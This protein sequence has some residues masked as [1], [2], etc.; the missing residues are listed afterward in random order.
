MAAVPVAVPAAPFL[1]PDNG[2]YYEAVQTP[3]G[4]TWDAAHAAAQ[5]LTH[6]GVTGHLATITSAAENQFIVRNFPQAITGGFW[7]G[8]VQPHGLLDPAAGWQWVTGEPFGYTNWNTIEFVEPNDFWGPGTGDQDENRL[9][10]WF[11]AEGRWN[12]LRP[13]DASPQ[14]YVVEYATSPGTVS[15]TNAVLFV[16]AINGVPTEGRPDQ[17]TINV[18]DC[19]TLT[20][21][22]KFR[23]GEFVDITH[24]P[25][26]RFFTEL[27]GQRVVLPANNFCATEAERNKIFTIY[28]QNFSPVAGQAITDTVIV[29]VRR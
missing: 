17:V 20:Y 12:D 19:V 7:L 24:S 1:N 28:G 27:G 11:S 14:G 23:T 10:Y 9:H 15:S 22:V 5:S 4:V 26:T 3:G 13:F 8:G 6:L 29:R 18:G 25:N 2:H 21:L 16:S